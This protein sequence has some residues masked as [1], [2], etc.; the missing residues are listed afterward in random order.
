MGAVLAGPHVDTTITPGPLSQ[1]TDSIG[2]DTVCSL[3]LYELTANWLRRWMDV[4]AN[5]DL[6]E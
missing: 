4:S 2:D 1:H 5:E 6:P 3:I